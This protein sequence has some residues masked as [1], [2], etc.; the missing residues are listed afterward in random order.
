MAA[1]KNVRST[2]VGLTFARLGTFWTHTF[3]DKAQVRRLVNMVHQTTSLQKFESTSNN[4]AGI[5]GEKDRVAN[6]VVTYDKRDVIQAGDKF[7]NDAGLTYGDAQS[8]QMIYGGGDTQFWALPLRTFIP[9]IIQANGRRLLIGIDFFVL[10]DEWI[11][12]RSN[13]VDLFGDEW[14]LIQSGKRKDLDWLLSRSI[15]TTAPDTTEHVVNYARNDQSPK[16]F[17]LALASVA[18]MKILKFDQRLLIARPVGPVT[19][20][21]FDHETIRVEYPHERLEVGKLYRKN[22]IIGDGIKVHPGGPVN[23]AWWR[24]IDWRGGLSLDPIID[25]KG[26]FLKDE[27]V[28]AYASGTDPDSIGGSKVHTRLDLTGNWDLEH[29]Y[30]DRMSA[31]ETDQG[32]FLN[33]VLGMLTDQYA[34][35]VRVDNVGTGYVV[36]DLIVPALGSYTVQMVVRVTSVDMSGGVTGLSIEEPGTYTITPENSVQQSS[37][38]GVGVDVTFTALWAYSPSAYDALVSQTE[39]ANQLNRVLGYPREQLNPK[40][41]PHTKLTNPIDVFFLAGLNPRCMVITLDQSVIPSDRQPE[42]FRYLARELP[43]GVLS[44]VFCYAPGLP[45][46]TFGL[47]DST[48]A[49]DIV[50]FNQDDLHAPEESFDLGNSL[51]FVTISSETT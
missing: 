22:H 41:L 7:Y 50:E 39:R 29:L 13:P 17:E 48:E 42:L 49:V 14:F 33:S 26:L 32:F 11:L 43:L 16:A 15:G 4:L 37:T 38:T 19:T 12:F 44:I 46:D 34:T 8:Y 25:F 20:Y 3:K 24:A 27:D 6:V 36:D 10:K 9:Y 31:R 30:W 2:R 1:P 47:G 5:S 45:E 28:T 40:V 35:S 18:G 23:P 51:D 21:T